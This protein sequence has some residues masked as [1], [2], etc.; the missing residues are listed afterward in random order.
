MAVLRT[1][2]RH[3]ISFFRGLGIGVFSMNA[4]LMWT[5]A[6]DA[7]A[8]R[9][10]VFAIAGVGMALML[11][12]VCVQV[13]VDYLRTRRLLGRAPPLTPLLLGTG[14]ACAVAGVVVGLDRIL[15]RQKP[16]LF[17]GGVIVLA[18][19]LERARRVGIFGKVGTEPK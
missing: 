5:L 14:A 8:R 11:V 6:S 7:A 19:V 10:A 9:A 3:R 13:C 18:F 16:W 12:C 15:E 1:A 4:L 17:L 2:S